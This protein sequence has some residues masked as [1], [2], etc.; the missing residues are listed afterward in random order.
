[1]EANADLADRALAT[2]TRLART[3]TRAATLLLLATIV[4][5][6]GAFLLGLEA[7]SGGIESVWIVLAFFFGAIAIGCAARARFRIGRVRRHI[8]EIAADIRGLVA[9]GRSDV[10]TIVI[11][12]DQL[13]TG[14]ALEVSRGM[15]GMEGM[16][17]VNSQALAN[18]ENFAD[19]LRAITTFPLL[20]IV[21]LLITSVF[22]FLGLIFLIA[23][24][25]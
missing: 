22:A 14:S 21:T 4:I 13:A 23:L 18:S 9:D 24:A 5:C 25:L 17:R 7:L 3:V 19:A 1:M 12:D 10:I 11:P 20:A 8:P 6:V 15:S 16:R 2:I